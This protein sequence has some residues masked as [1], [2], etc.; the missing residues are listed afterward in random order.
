MKK[1][2]PNRC[3]PCFLNVDFELHQK[4]ICLPGNGM[5]HLFQLIFNVVETIHELLKIMRHP[6]KKRR[7]FGVLKVLKL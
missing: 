7:D 5:L 4:F 6:A 1:S 3:V 2:T